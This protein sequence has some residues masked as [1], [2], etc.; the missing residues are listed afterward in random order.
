MTFAL[1]L[2]VSVPAFA[3][4]RA[5]RPSWVAA[6]LAWWFLGLFFVAGLYLF[7][8]LASRWTKRASPDP[9]ARGD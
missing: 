6:S 4:W 7:E 1:V 5:G 9:Q 2:G 3:S 8:A